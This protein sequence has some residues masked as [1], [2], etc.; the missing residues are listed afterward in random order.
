[1]RKVSLKRKSGRRSGRV[2]ADR[3]NS[4]T[5]EDNGEAS[6]ESDTDLEDTHEPENK[7][8]AGKRKSVSFSAKNKEDADPQYEVSWISIITNV[9]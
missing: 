5:R 7:K 9:F 1:M 2:A 8:R 3:S 4:S 6:I